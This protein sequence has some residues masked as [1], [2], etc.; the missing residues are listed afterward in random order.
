MP[1]NSRKDKLRG[2]S[3]KE[4]RDHSV[5]NVNNSDASG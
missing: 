2:K 1:R 3:P 4:R 5:A